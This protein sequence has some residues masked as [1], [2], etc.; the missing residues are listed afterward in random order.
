[1]LEVL[2]IIQRTKSK[3]Q[4]VPDKGQLWNRTGLESLVIF[5]RFLE[6]ESFN[7]ILEEFSCYIP[8]RIEPRLVEQWIG[9]SLEGRTF[10]LNLPKCTQH[11]RLI[12]LLNTLCEGC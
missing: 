1:M 9:L 8:I 2:V 3:G 6:L 5:R 4:S 11:E 10:C 7:A 12:I